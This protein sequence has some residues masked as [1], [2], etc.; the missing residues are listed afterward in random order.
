MNSRRNFL[1]KAALTGAS[2]MAVPSLLGNSFVEE[3]V[4]DNA[5]AAEC[6][7]KLI[8]PKA[9]GLQITGIF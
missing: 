8:V 7:G 9:Q 3:A 1:K 2:V 6:A 4:S 5:V